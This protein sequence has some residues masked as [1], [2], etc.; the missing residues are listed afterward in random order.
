MKLE[1]QDPK[2]FVMPRCYLSGKHCQRDGANP[3]A[4]QMKLSFMR[5]CVLLNYH[6]FHIQISGGLFSGRLFKS[7]QNFLIYLLEGLNRMKKKNLIGFVIF[8]Y[9]EPI[10]FE[11][12]I[13]LLIITNY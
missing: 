3:S 13:L 10:S 2:I 11:V 12:K 5:M 8:F 7:K 6:S 4:N 9:G 1:H